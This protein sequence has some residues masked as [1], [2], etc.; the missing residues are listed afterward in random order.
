M[1]PLLLGMVLS[2]S[3]YTV[4]HF[5]TFSVSLNP[6][7]MLLVS[8]ALYFVAMLIVSVALFTIALN[9]LGAHF[10]AFIDAVCLQNSRILCL[11]MSV[12]CFSLMYFK[13]I[14]AV[15]DNTGLVAW[16]DAPFLAVG[17]LVLAYFGTF[18]H[19]QVLIVF[20]PYALYVRQTLKCD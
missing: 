15:A 14:D 12:L 3:I 11:A 9:L 16:I 4:K 20:Q 2:I 18:G 1:N 8:A 13:V 7:A 6:V 5:L 10:Q 17:G 19:R